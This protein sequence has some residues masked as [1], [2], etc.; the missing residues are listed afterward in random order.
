M[1]KLTRHF[2]VPVLLNASEIVELEEICEETGSSQSGLLRTSLKEKIAKHRNDKQR[3]E[4]KELPKF[5]QNMC[6][7]LPGR[8]GVAPKAYMRC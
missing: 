7:F 3:K 8:Y 2:R 6:M 5:A 1:K 4:K